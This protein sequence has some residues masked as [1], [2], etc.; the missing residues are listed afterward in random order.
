D[1]NTKV[2][3]KV[4]RQAYQLDMSLFNC[5]GIRVGWSSVIAIIPVQVYVLD[6]FMAFMVLRTCQEVQGGLPKGVQAKVIFNSCYAGRDVNIIMDFGVGLV[7]LI[8][9]IADV[10]FRANTRNAMVLKEYLYEKAKK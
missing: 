1:H 9:D 5:C 7:P 8:G 6:A 4:Q 2:L 10:L 3:N